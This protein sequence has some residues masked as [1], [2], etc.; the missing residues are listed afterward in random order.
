MK[1]SMVRNIL[2]QYIQKTG[3]SSPVLFLA[4]NLEV[5]H[6]EIVSNI[7]TIFHEHSMDTQSMFHLIDD[8]ETLK[9]HTVK[10]CIA[11]GNI[12]P[13][14]AFQVFFIERLDRM[15]PQAQN[16]CLKF[17]EEPGEGNIIILTNTSEAGILE[18]IV[19]RVQIHHIFQTQTSQKSSF[20]ASSTMSDATMD[21]YLSMITSHIQGSS[22]ALVKYFFSE[23]YETQEYIHFLR[24]IVCYISQ[25]WKYT[26]LLE[27]LQEDMQ[28]IMKHNLQARYIVDTYIM[29]LK[30]SLS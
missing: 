17:F 14:F 26:H 21:F 4:E 2:T 9:I 3:E 24:A 30:S 29:Q 11:Q 27:K 6:H 23:K 19:S 28:G 7:T 12:K 25:T 1:N 5:L 10:Q 13:R 8:G 15:T 20:G 16:A 18:T 22:D